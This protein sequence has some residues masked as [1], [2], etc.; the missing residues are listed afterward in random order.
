MACWRKSIELDPKDARAHTVLGIALAQQK[1]LD[2]AMACWRKAIELD[3]RD[4]R[5]HTGLGLALAQQK[6]LDEAMACWRKAI[7]LD[8]KYAA[9]HNGL[10]WHLATADD[11]K[12][13]DFPKALEHARKATELAPGDPN[14]WEN[15]GVAQHRCGDFAGAVAN[16][17]KVGRMPGGKL[18]IDAHFF[19][20]M[21]YWRAG[22]QEAARKCYAEAVVRANNEPGRFRTEAEQVMGIGAAGKAESGKG[23][24]ESGKGKAER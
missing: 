11:P 12:V 4:A 20:A 24:T 22:N 14:A 7:E 8:P 13:L 23:K 21:A 1:K 19:L 10:A 9:A 3:P 15:L 2:E 5:A 16:L 17:E 18:S 6:K